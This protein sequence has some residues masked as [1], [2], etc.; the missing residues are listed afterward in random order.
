MPRITIT[1]FAVA[2]AVAASVAHAQESTFP[3]TP[4]ASKH[5]SYPS[6]IPYQADTDTNLIRGSQFGYNLCNS[7]TEGQDSLCQTSFLN[8]LDGQSKPKSLR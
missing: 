8:H 6:G 7:T 3:A 2:L 1:P 4:L 5:F